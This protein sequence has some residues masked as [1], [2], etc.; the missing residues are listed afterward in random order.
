MY[1]LPVPY[2]FSH[3]RFHHPHECRR[4]ALWDRVWGHIW[5]VLLVMPAS[6]PIAIYVLVIGR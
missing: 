4:F 1:R 6:L 5:P 2:C 3:S